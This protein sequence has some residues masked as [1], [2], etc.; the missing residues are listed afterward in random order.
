MTG[1]LASP[2]ARILEALTDA[3]EAGDP[4]P[5]NKVLAERLG[6]GRKSVSYHVLRLE[7][8]GLI[9]RRTTPGGLRAIRIAATGRETRPGANNIGHERRADR[10]PVCPECLIRLA[11]DGRPD[12]RT[13]PC[14]RP[15]CPYQRPGAFRPVHETVSPIGGM[16]ARCLVAGL[17]IPR[18]IEPCAPERSVPAGGAERQGAACAKDTC[19]P[20]RSVP[21]G[22]AERQGAARADN[23]VGR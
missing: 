15:E 10:S 11:A 2:A 12:R 1:A 14:P 18:R 21:S 20:E 5:S 13:M 3:A 16:Y 4:C 9:E 22:G 8:A 19:A 7:E 6:I 23:T 17:D